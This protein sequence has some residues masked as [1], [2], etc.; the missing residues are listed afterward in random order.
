MK[1]IKL[2]ENYSEIIVYHGTNDKHQFNNNG[3][4]ARGT[5]FSTIDSEAKSYGKY[6]Y[7]AVLKEGLN[8]FNTK[9]INDLNLLFS[10]FDVLYDTYYSE[11]EPEYEITSA[12]QLLNMNDDWEPIENTPGVLNWLENSYDGVWL[13]EGGVKNILLFSPVNDKLKSINL[14]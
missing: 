12:E 4:I 1:W 3:Y 14:V 9:N 13:Y 8:L 11:D 6:L 2:F 5:F 7:K 10:R